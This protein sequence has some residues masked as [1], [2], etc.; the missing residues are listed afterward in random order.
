[1]ARIEQ[2]AGL[3][4]PFDLQA[5]E[6]KLRETS[7][8][9][10]HPALTSARTVARL[11]DQYESEGILAQAYYRPTAIDPWSSCRPRPCSAGRG[12]SRSCRR[13]TSASCAPP[14]MPPVPPVITA[15]RCIPPAYSA[16]AGSTIQDGI[17][18][19]SVR[20]STPCAGL[21]VAVSLMLGAAAAMV[22]CGHSHV[23]FIGVDKGLLDLS[24]PV[25][26]YIGK[27]WSKAARIC[28]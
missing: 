20:V 4:R 5:V 16:V 15:V 28:C 10:Q 7:L 13:R 1:M 23:P 26:F 14:P 8:D 11:L 6:A 9:N 12:R 25:D 22:V 24:K 27:G 19:R 18:G 17:S 21:A 2:D 3:V